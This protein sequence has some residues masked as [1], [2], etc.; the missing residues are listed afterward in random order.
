MD[1][2]L[3]G[4]LHAIKRRQMDLLH[5]Q[6]LRDEDGGDGVSPGHHESDR[7]IPEYPL[8]AISDSFKMRPVGPEIAKNDAKAIIC[9][10]VDFMSESVS[11][12]MSKERLRT[13]PRLS[14]RH[15][16]HRLLPRR[17]RRGGRVQGLAVQVGRGRRRVAPRCV[18]QHVASVVD[19]VLKQFSDAYV[20]A[21]L[22]VQGEM[23]IER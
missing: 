18:H 5:H 11:A 3:Q 12:I 22:E 23:R 7:R 14:R 4:V 1:V 10:G 17:E 16:A 2:E 19:T 6:K 20:T 21:H 13:R 8:V 9:L 15:P